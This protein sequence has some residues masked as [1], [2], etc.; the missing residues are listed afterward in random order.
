MEENYRNAGIAFALYQVAL[1]DVDGLLYLHHI[2]KDGSGQVTHSQIKSA[3]D[4]ETPF[5]VTVEEIQA[6]RLDSMFTAENLGDLSYIVKLDVDGAEE[7][8]IAGGKRVISHA[9]FVVIEVP[10]TTKPFCSRIAAL[11]QC[12]FSVFDICDNAYYFGQLSQVDVVMINNR[13]RDAELKFR[14]WQYSEGQVVWDKWQH[15]F[16]SLKGQP[17]GDPFI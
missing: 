6:R 11:E 12:G 1:S 2:S 9:S 16:Q 4:W 15:G 14:P 3:P 17:V 10:V 5:L 7:R 8:I 13:L